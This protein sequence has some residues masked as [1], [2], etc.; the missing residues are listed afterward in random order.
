MLREGGE[1]I[2]NQAM[3][4]AKARGMHKSYGSVDPLEWT[5]TTPW[6]ALED[7]DRSP[8]LGDSLHLWW[9]PLDAGVAPGAEPR[10]AKRRLARQW[11]L[12]ILGRYLG[13]APEQIILAT[14]AGGRPTLSMPDAPFEFNLSHSGERMLLAIGRWRCG[15]DVEWLGRTRDFPALAR[16]VLGAA[17]LEWFKALPASEQQRGFIRLW[18]AKEAA[19]KALSRGTESLARVRFR[20]GA[21]GELEPVTLPDMAGDPSAWRVLEFTPEPGYQAALA[22]LAPTPDILGFRPVGAASAAIGNSDRG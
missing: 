4:G 3:I 9:L 21:K 5:R 19:L 8:A 1:R 22:G 6:L 14:E 15:V 17:E 16:H 10:G 20:V 2:H 11:L 13:W 18:A 12:R 7:L